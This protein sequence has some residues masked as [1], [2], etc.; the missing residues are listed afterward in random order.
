M[1]GYKVDAYIKALAP[2]NMLRMIRH[3]AKHT[4]RLSPLRW[5][6]NVRYLNW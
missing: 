3:Y 4:L 1:F 6:S 2:K 5:F